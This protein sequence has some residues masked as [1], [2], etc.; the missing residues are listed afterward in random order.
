MATRSGTTSFGGSLVLV[1]VAGP[2]AKP[3][4]L[5][6][7]KAVVIGRSKEADYVLADPIVSRR[8]CTVAKVGGRWLLTDL[9]SRHGVVLNSTKLQSGQAVVIDEGDLIGIGPWTFHVG[10]GSSDVSFVHTT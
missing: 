9:N 6:A 4:T 8:H 2:P 1:P 3:L 7:G 5:A 10:M